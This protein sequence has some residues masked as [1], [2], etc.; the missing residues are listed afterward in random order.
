MDDVE[1]V[2]R[3]L[4]LIGLELADQVQPNARETFLQIRPF[5]GGLLHAILAEV[6]VAGFE[7]R[8]D[9]LGGMSLGDSDQGH[10]FRR[11]FCQPGGPC[12]RAAHSQQPP[13]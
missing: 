7:Q 11:A 2:D 13:L 5:R 9:R 3:V 12:H 8:H 6:D 10:C 1:Q 4:R